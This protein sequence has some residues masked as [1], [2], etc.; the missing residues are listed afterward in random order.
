MTPAISAAFLTSRV[1]CVVNKI[2]ISQKFVCDNQSDNGRHIH[3]YTL[4]FALKEPSRSV[5]VTSVLGEISCFKR[6]FL[7][8]SFHFMILCGIFCVTRVL[9]IRPPVKDFSYGIFNFLS[10]LLEVFGFSARIS[11]H[12][13]IF[14]RLNFQ[15]AKVSNVKHSDMNEMPMLRLSSEIMPVKTFKRLL[16]KP[17]SQGLSGPHPYK[18][19]I[20]RFDTRA[21][22]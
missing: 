4:S 1:S 21:S 14:G 15:M 8:S 5:P 20:V 7:S 9:N 13:E 12:L 6:L 2:V 11:Q 16:E 22:M 18:P 3:F 10:S 17:K 19:Y